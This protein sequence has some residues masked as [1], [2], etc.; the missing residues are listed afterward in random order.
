MTEQELKATVEQIV[1]LEAMA[2]VL[3]DGDEYIRATEMIDDAQRMEEDLEQQGFV[4]GDQ[5]TKVL[6]Y[7]C[8]IFGKARE[9]WLAF[10]TA[11]GQWRKAEDVQDR[12]HIQI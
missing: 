11:H 2:D 3:I 4:L 5:D 9:L 8:D 6:V 12:D 10:D 1:S 7:R